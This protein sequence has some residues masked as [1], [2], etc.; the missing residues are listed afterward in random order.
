[1]ARFGRWGAGSAAVGLLLAIAILGAV[2]ATVLARTQRTYKISVDNPH[3]TGVPNHDFEYVDYFPRERVRLH[4]TDVLDFNWNTG[5][6]DGAHTVSFVPASSAVPGLFAPDTD[7][8]GVPL[9]FNP[10]MFFPSDPSCGTKTTPC[11]Y[12]GTA[13]VNS[14]FI[15]NAVGGDFYV[16][17]DPKLLHGRDSVDIKYICEVHPGMSGSVTL[18]DDRREASSPEEVRDRAADQFEQDTDAALRQE[19]RDNKATVELN[20]DGTHK[21]TA[22]AGTATQFV[23]IVEM[24]PATIKVKP[25]DTVTWVTKTQ[26]DPHTVTFPQGHGSDSVDPLLPVC[27]ATVDVP[28]PGLNPGLCSNPS[29]FEVHIAPQPQGPTAITS[30]A[31]VATSGLI[32]NAPGVPN[33]YSFTFPNAGTFAYQ[34]RI[35]DNMTGIVIAKN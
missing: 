12:D 6:V 25:G 4:S 27:E 14:G 15:P 29:Q 3:A 35:H 28:V 17:L 8:A 20:P 24:L 32:A 11:V 5:A 22:I 13:I 7:D 18:V 19:R 9:E 34:C 16:K 10:Q 33:S 1:M 2:P 30:P 26:K 23:E 31:T 21:V